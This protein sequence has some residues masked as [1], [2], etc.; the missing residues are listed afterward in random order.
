MIDEIDALIV[1]R[2][3]DDGNVRLR[4]CV[5][6][7][8]RKTGWA[9]AMLDEAIST[10]ALGEKP[11]VHSDRGCHYRWPGWLRRLE[12][13]DLTQPMSRKGCTPDNAACEALFGRLKVKL[14]YACQ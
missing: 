4:L 10:L 3:D 13:A 6:G 11:V 1:A 7:A 9:N 12:A 14:S 8:E 2:R 5:T